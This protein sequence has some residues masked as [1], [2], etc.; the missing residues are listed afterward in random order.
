MTTIP[1]PLSLSLSPAVINSTRAPLSHPRSWGG[2]VKGKYGGGEEGDD[3][4]ERG[5]VEKGKEEGEDD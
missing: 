3:D 5:E 2:G 1:L 4:E